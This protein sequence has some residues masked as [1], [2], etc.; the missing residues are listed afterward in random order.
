MPMRQNH[1]GGKFYDFLCEN[2]FRL[3]SMTKV[4]GA[5]EPLQATYPPILYL[6]PGGAGRTVL[7]PAEAD[8]EGL[9]FWIR[10]IADAAEVLTIEEDSA[11]TTIVALAQNEGCMVHCDGTTWRAFQTDIA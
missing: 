8:S 1:I 4:V 5:D 11:T 2:G 9:C 6:D 10:N 3:A 7:L